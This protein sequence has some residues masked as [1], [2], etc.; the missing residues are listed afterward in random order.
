MAFNTL[1]TAVCLTK[2]TKPN[3]LSI[4]SSTIINT[5][6]PSTNVIKITGGD[7]SL[8]LIDS[9][10]SITIFSKKATTL[11]YVIVGGGGGG[12]VGVRVGSGNNVKGGNGGDG[13]RV[14]IGSLLINSGETTIYCFVGAGGKTGHNPQENGS[15]GSMSYITVYLSGFTISANGGVGGQG[16]DGS[17]NSINNPVNSS[18]LYTSNIGKGGLGGC[19]TVLT[20]PLA[21]GGDGISINIKGITYYFGGGGGGGNRIPIPITGSIPENPGST[22]YGGGYSASGIYENSRITKIPGMYGAI[23]FGGGGGGGTGSDSATIWDTYPRY[24]NPGGKGVI[25]LYI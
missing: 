9:S 17:A 21:Q 13:G 16:G 2:N 1:N 20:D 24:G 25:Y 6:D 11:Y 14:V 5:F 23:N 15:D 10:G 8:N 3:Y 18:S 4:V 22:L 7:S 19:S 12:G